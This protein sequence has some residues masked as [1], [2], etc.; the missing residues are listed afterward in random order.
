MSE[1]EAQTLVGVEGEV[2]WFDS[3]KGFGF[4]VGP[5]GQDVFVHYSVIDGSGYRSL[6]DGTTVE[7]DAE[8]TEKGW[9]ASR[10]VCHGTVEVADRQAKRRTPE[11]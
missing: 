1:R 6:R 5:E 2:K 3:R 9:K 11:S 8:R 7:Y 10:V 4:I